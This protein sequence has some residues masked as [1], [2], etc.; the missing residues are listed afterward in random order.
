MQAE[1][2]KEEEAIL[3]PID[4][5]TIA[6]YFA[7]IGSIG[8]VVSVR[9][10]KAQRAADG[11]NSEGYFLAERSVAWWAVAASLF[12]SNIGAEHF[13]G[14]AGLAAYSGVAVGFYEWG[15]IVCMLVLGYLFL[16]VYFNSKVQTMP[17]WLEFRYNTFC[18]TFLVALSLVLYILTKIAATLFAGELMLTEISHVNKWV[19]IVLL[20]MG[21]ALYTVTGGLAAVIYTETLQTLVLFAGG[22][23]LLIA[24]LVKVGGFPSLMQ[25]E[26]ESQPHY[27]QIFRPVTADFPWTGLLTG[28]YTT[29]LWYWCTD[30]VIVQRAIAAKNVQHGRAGC[31]GGSF[32]KLLPGFLMV[33]PGM[34]A[35]KLMNEQGVLTD[36]SPRSEYDRAFTWLVLECMPINSRGIIVAAMVSA[37]M[38]SLASV[39]N[40]CATIFT[41][42][43]YKKY[44]PYA[45]ETELVW[46]GRAVVV[47]V[48]ALSCAWLPVIP[49]LGDQLFLWIQ[50]PPSYIAPPVLALY[51]WGCLFE[52]VNAKGASACLILGVAVGT[53]RFLLEVGQAVMHMNGS[54]VPILTSFVSLNFLHFSAINFVLSS[55]VLFLVSIIFPAKER[56]DISHMLWK[57]NLY[58]SLLVRYFS[59]KCGQGEESSNGE[60]EMGQLLRQGRKSD[61]DGVDDGDGDGFE[62]G[63]YARNPSIVALLLCS[64]SPQISPRP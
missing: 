60:L 52:W 2:Q 33:V 54:D 51:M 28:Y 11:R 56:G 43:I 18:G 22:F 13:V 29:S 4:A 53:L 58:D 42:D 16:P 8:I 37:L 44:K 47:A 41:Y 3:G 7:A 12:A 55:A 38:S 48:A 64:N 10:A 35:R 9:Q 62:V 14:L 17:K 23:A 26:Y 24:A 49:L 40:S 30:Q 61:G 32:L 25:T 27:F 46:V 57:G 50:K 34:I 21:T 20:I 1:P 19:A 5:L 39:F 63:L 45:A 15:A 36:E 31:V 59:D 6:V